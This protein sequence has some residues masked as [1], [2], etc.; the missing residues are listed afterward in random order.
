MQILGEVAAGIAHDVQ[1]SNQKISMQVQKPR[2]LLQMLRDLV[3]KV[4]ED[5]LA[6]ALNAAAQRI[7]RFAQAAPQERM[8]RATTAKALLI[9]IIDMLI[10][11]L[12]LPQE[13]V[14]ETARKIESLRSMSSGAGDAYRFQVAE[15]ISEE[16]LQDLLTDDRVQMKVK[17]N[18]PAPMVEVDPSRFREAIRALVQNAIDAM[19]ESSERYL[20]ISVQSLELDREAMRN[21]PK[22][23]LNRHN[24]RAGRYVRI[25][26]SDTGHGIEQ[27]KLL[28]IFEFRV[29]SHNDPT[30]EENRRGFGL[31]IV[32]SI[33]NESKGFITVESALDEGSVFTLYIPEADFEFSSGDLL[34]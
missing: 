34:G 11:Q 1:N 14:E 13:T 28:N 30:L 24:I 23:R 7:A 6:V 12:L 8:E 5:E 31:A 25:D 4:G 9:A 33:V 18:S 15:L 17:V 32:Q 2:R 3:I 20:E 27:D 19:R 21:M 22:H 29:S 10:P 16:A 26:F